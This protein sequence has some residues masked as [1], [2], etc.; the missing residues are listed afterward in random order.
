MVKFE[1]YIAIYNTLMYLSSLDFLLVQYTDLLLKEY[2]LHTMEVT[3]LED[4][5]FFWRT[6]HLICTLY[7]YVSTI[8][9][10]TTNSERLENISLISKIS[11]YSGRLTSTQNISPVNSGVIK[12]KELWKECSISISHVVEISNSQTAKSCCKLV[13]HNCF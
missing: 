5:D 13:V 2:D 9:S 1:F 7:G 4:I 11:L 12:S 3:G 8:K 6:N 10:I